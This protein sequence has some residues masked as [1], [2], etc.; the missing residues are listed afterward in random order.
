MKLAFF[1]ICL[2]LPVSGLSDT[3][4]DAAIQA[5]LIQT[6]VADTISKVKTYVELRVRGV[7]DSTGLTPVLVPV[8]FAHRVITT[9]TLTIPV[10]RDKLN[11][12][13]DSIQLEIPL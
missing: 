7:V 6:G 8:L 5:T 2:L 12:H 10:G 1:L 11:L 4:S 3:A 13:P 9:K